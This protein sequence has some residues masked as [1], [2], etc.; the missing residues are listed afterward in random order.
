MR[1]RTAFT[2]AAVLAAALMAA[3]PGCA[4]A[5]EPEGSALP[6]DMIG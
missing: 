5:P 4:T 1:R 2:F 3:A 6:G